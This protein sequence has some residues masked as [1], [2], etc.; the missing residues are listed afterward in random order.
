VILDPLTLAATWQSEALPLGTSLAVGNVDSDAALEIVTAGGYVID[1]ATHAVEWTYAGGFGLAVDTGDLDGDGVEEIVGMDSWSRFRGFSGLLKAPLWEQ[2]NF[3]NDALLVTDLDGDGVAEIVVGDGQWGN[4]TAY[5]YR[6]ATNDLAVLWKVDSQESG[7]SSLAAADLDGDG[8]PEVAWGSG[9]GS[10]G[11]DVLAVAGASGLKWRSGDPWSA[12]SPSQLDGP[13]LGAVPARL[14]AGAAPVLLFQTASSNSGYD[15]ARL[16]RLD[17]SGAV[18]VSAEI[19]TNWSGN[20]ALAVA[21]FEGDGV[22]EAFLAT[23]SL[24]DGYLVAWDFLAGAPAWTSPAGIGNGRAVVA[25][26]LN[27]DGAPDLVTVTSEGYVMAY[28]V[29][30]AALIFKSTSIGT[31]VS[32][33]VADLDGSGDE[34]IVALTAS[35]LVVFHKAPSGPVPWLEGDSIAVSGVDLAVADCDGDG[36]PEIY[37]LTGTYS[38]AVT[39]H[40]FDGTLAET[41]SFAVRGAAQSLFVED[42]GFARKNLVL[43]KSDPYGSSGAPSVLEAVDAVTGGRIWTSP[44]LA[45]TVPR[46]SLRY[47][48]LDGDGYREIAFGTSTGMHLTR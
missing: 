42:L 46:A 17:P 38:G 3:D 41:G 6:P 24:Y 28:D 1:G 25:A 20:G 15:G 9:A 27:G 7:V 30:H 33:A 8:V 5:Q 19:G 12:V 44:P 47:V 21:D 2:S 40:R 39:V 36:L 23:A 34:K 31:G 4:V 43:G 16:V 29:L 35:R 48:D 14:S 10:S 37:L 45:G 32:V 13:Y 22:D 11:A 18:S 26:D